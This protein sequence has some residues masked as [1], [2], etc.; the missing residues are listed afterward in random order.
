M[1][2]V[3]PVVISAS[4]RT[5][6]VGCYPEYLIEKLRAYPPENVHTIVIWTKNPGNMTRHQAL[7]EALSQ[8]AQVY[9]QLTITGLGGSPLEPGI[10][11]W[12]RVEEMIPELMQLVKGPKRISWRFDPI[13]AAENCSGL[14]ENLPLFPGMAEKIRRQGITTCRTSWASPYKKVIR[15][16]Q[17]KGL[18]LRTCSPEEQAAQAQGLE[19]IAGSLGIKIYYCS[20]QGF[21]RSR[22]IDGAL[23]SMLHPQSL[24]CSTKK[25][26]GQ[27]AACGC[28]ESIDIGWYSL[29]CAHG[30]IYCYAEPRTAEI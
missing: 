20:M 15:R 4:R 11:P 24:P 17:K 22:C 2:K 26:R 27:R 21:E 8:Y 6:L 1:D 14:I 12:E 18:A 13:I 3:L 7:R 19:E 10:P 16:M 30:C 29:K 25:A 5:D 28:T 9:V 23:L